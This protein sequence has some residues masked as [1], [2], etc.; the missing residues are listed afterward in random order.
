[1]LQKLN[2]RIQG[3]VAWLV[4][5]LIAFTFTLF[6]LDYYLQS[7]QTSDAKVVVNDQ[8]ITKQAFETNY[9]RTRAQQDMAQMTAGDEKNLQNQ[10]L[11]QMITNEVTVQSAR[12]YGFEVSPEQANAAIVNIPQFQEDGHFSTERYQQALSGALFTPETFQNEV[13]QGMLLNQ[14][15]FAFMGS[16]FALPGEINRFVRLYM[17]TRDYEY[18]TVPAARFKKEIKISEDK[19]DEYYT[20]HEKEF[21]MPEQVSIDFVTLSMG[22]I[23]S[24]I[25]ISNEDVKRYYD[26][27]QSNFLTPAQWQVAHILFAVPDNASQDEMENAQKKAEAAFDELKKNPDH[28]NRLVASKSDDKLSIAGKGILPWITAGQNEYGKILAAM[29]EPGKI[30]RPE[31]TKHGYEIFKLIAYKPVTIRSLADVD[32]MIRE[33]LL[34]DMAQTQY[35]Q[36]LEQLSDLS[37]QSPDSLTPVSDALDLKIQHSEPFSRLGGTTPLAQNKQVV[38]AAFSHDVLDLGNNSDPV[39]LDNDSVMVLRVNAHIPAKQQPLFAVHGEIEKIL[40]KQLAEAKAKEIGSYLLNP[41]EDK[42]QQ[43]LISTHK[44]KWHE[45]VKAARDNEKS[46]ALINDLAFNLLRPESRDGIILENG[47][48]VVVRLKRINDGQLT[49]LDQEQRTSLIQQ[50]EASYGMMDYD[51]YVNNLTK[52]AKIVKS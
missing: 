34:T 8:S 52:K 7:H 29:T 18:L 17:Q 5:I 47:D 21:M 6:G 1:M 33:Q 37:Y 24:K 3:V 44:L 27:N 45:V 9:R 4:I 15:R 43:E 10:V 20:K 46:S 23:R 35:A 22:D 49:Y 51:L 11:N 48:Y 32:S 30:S 28:F 13:R 31:K 25:K 36:A 50:I 16:S 41:V 40:T 12:H 14:Q 26:E 2:E 38:N 42:Q 39:Q 19:I